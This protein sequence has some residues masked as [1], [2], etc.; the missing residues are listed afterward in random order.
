[1]ETTITQL[2]KR[3][4]GFYQIPCTILDGVQYSWAIPL[5]VSHTDYR[6]TDRPTQRDIHLHSSVAI[7]IYLALLD[8][9]TQGNT[10]AD[11][12]ATGGEVRRVKNWSKKGGILLEIYF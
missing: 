9:P 5:D 11:T 7:S 8:R 10:H 6:P 4:L 1:M 2:V 3:L 12:H